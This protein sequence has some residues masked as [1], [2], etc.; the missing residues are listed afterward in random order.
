[1]YIYIFKLKMFLKTPNC[2]IGGI[3]KK[4]IFCTCMKS[5]VHL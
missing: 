4:Y 5:F 1:M 2:P 3:H